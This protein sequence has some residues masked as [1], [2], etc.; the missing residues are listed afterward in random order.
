MSTLKICY[1][2]CDGCGQKF[3]NGERHTI[4]A[5]RRAAKRAGWKRRPGSVS[6]G[7][8]FCPP[9]GARRIDVR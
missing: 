2:L 5:T 6:V 1:L 3:G 7:A 8:D 4:A 9:C